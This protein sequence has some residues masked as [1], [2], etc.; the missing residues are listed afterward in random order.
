MKK[1]SKE[2]IRNQFNQFASWCGVS[3]YSK[4]KTIKELIEYKKYESQFF[5]DD[6][7]FNA[8]IVKFYQFLDDSFNEEEKKNILSMFGKEYFYDIVQYAMS[9]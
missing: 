3:P 2:E 8:G 7:L 5:G 1:L 9:I 4:G 6:K